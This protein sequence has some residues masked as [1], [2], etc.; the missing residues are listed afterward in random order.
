MSSEFKKKNADEPK[1][2]YSDAEY[3]ALSVHPPPPVMW[4]NSQAGQ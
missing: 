1:K 3:F 4:G 2:K